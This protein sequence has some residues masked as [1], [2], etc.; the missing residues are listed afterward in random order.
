MSEIPGPPEPPD[1]LGPRASRQRRFA[2]Q[3]VYVEGTPNVYT[4]EVFGQCAIDGLPVIIME[5]EH[6]DGIDR[7]PFRISLSIPAAQA[8]C[9]C[10][11]L[12]IDDQCERHPELLDELE[13]FEVVSEVEGEGGGECDGYEGDGCDGG[14]F[15]DDEGSD[16]GGD[17]F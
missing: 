9:E 13:D 15:L 1:S 5:D 11:I 16:E 2:N 6:G 12:A 14:E 10:L 8:L 7:G 17:G 3:A 4:G